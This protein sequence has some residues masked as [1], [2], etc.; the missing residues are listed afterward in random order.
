MTRQ[1]SKSTTEESPRLDSIEHAIQDIRDGKVIILVDDEDRE[2]EG[3][4]VCAAEKVTPKIINFMATHARGLIC[5]PLDPQIADRLELPPM[6]EINRERMGT[7]FTVSVEAAQGVTTGISAADRAHTILTAVKLD[8]SPR[9][10]VSPGHVFPLR[11]KRGGVLVRAGQTEG[12][13]DL[14]GMAGL[15]RAGVICE[16]MDEDGTMARYPRLR[17]FADEH[18]LKLVSIEDLIAYRKAR[19]VLVKRMVEASL[20][21]DI[22]KDFRVVGYQNVHTD[23]D[24]IALVMGEWPEEEPVLV[25][26]HSQ[27]LTGDVF[28]SMRCDCGKQ[29]LAAMSIVA[30]EGKG[31]ILYLPQEG[32]GI[33]LINKLK[34]YNLQDGGADTVEANHRLGFKE[35]LRD[36]G[37]GAQILI[38]LGVRKMRLIT[39]NPRKI[40][41]LA[42]YQLEVVERVPLQMPASSENRKYLLAKKNKLGHLLDI[43]N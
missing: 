7:N 19:E 24:Y 13:V 37:I 17:R 43:E 29:L 39:N 8:S 20:P 26:V 10:L 1:R 5:M 11:A 42:G 6:V 12:S 25:R 34:A 18:G 38:D 30:D 22:S 28:R 36:Y 32:R 21:T 27:C 40:V 3:D 16:I 31:V 14:A 23:D 41:G 9:H 2:N 35:D 15:E 4:L 33:G